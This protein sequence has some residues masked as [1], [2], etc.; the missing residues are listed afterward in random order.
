MERAGRERMHAI[1]AEGEGE[2][3]FRV[4]VTVSQEEAA[5]SGA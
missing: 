1:T 2:V 3:Q 5:G 4:L